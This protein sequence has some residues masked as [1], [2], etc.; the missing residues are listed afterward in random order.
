VSVNAIERA[1][2]A[3]AYVSATKLK[4]EAVEAANALWREANAELAA[5]KRAP[6][7][8]GTVS[9]EGV[10]ETKAEK[11]A[12]HDREFDEAMREIT[13]KWD[14]ICRNPSA[15]YS[16]DGRVVF[17]YFENVPYYADRQAYGVDLYRTFDTGRV[18]GCAIWIDQLT[19]RQ[20]APDPKREA[21]AAPPLSPATPSVTVE[22]ALA[23]FR[24]AVKNMDDW[25]DIERGVKAVLA[26][27]LPR[28]PAKETSAVEAEVVERCAKVMDALAKERNALARSAYA[29]GNRAAAEDFSGEEAV[30]HDGSARIRALA[31]AQEGRGT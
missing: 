17:A 21:L 23:A 1:L 10:E 8:S 11:L 18:V 12:R 2:N 20:H 6:V 29:R 27:S 9:G 26:L 22:E 28:A 19:I 15:Y 16:P 13:A 5:L 24:V 14:G 25:D 3:Y 7:E 4:G 31:R 30:C